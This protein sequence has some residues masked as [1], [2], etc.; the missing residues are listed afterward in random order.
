ME[1]KE[2]E[3]KNFNKGGMLKKG[4]SAL[5]MADGCEP[6]TNYEI[7]QKLCKIALIIW[8]CFAKPIKRR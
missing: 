5:K 6:L 2:C 4:M 3:N 1:K 8:T 7:S